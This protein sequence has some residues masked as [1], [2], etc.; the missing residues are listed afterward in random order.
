M[1]NENQPA[2]FSPA[3]RRGFL[4]ALGVHGLGIAAGFPSLLGRASQALACQ[5]KPKEEMPILVVLELA[6][7]NDGLN[8]VVPHGID[9]Y[10]RYR[11]KLAISPDE[12]LKLDEQFG[13][14]P[15]LPGLEALF[16]E[17]QLA[18]VHGC[19]YP[20]PSFSHTESALHWHSAL[21]QEEDQL[22]WLGRV[23]DLRDSRPRT[24]ALVNLG[25]V[26]SRAVKSRRHWPLLVTPSGDFEENEDSRPSEA[27]GVEDEVLL[28]L[29]RLPPLPGN[30]S[31][32][33]IHDM[34]T[35][36]AETAALV[37]S[38][39]RNYRTPIDYGEGEISRQ[40]ALIASLIDVEFPARI[41]FVSY[42]GFDTHVAQHER[43]SRRISF[44]GRAFAAFLADLQRMG[45]SDRVASLVF[46]EFG[47]RPHENSG[48][49]TDH[50]TATP[51]LLAGGRVRGGFHGSFPSLRDLDEEGNVR[52]TTDF[53]SV[54][55]SLLRDWMGLEDVESVL[56]APFPRLDLFG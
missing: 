15:V 7:G 48:N 11:P 22:G 6:G 42:P 37:E 49:G 13:L 33:F 26:T 14:N 1:K 40:L 44:F 25:E 24:D 8:T 52:Y 20:N 18:V 27:R 53:R 3:T 51:V 17:G 5:G 32:D 34:S 45:R 41:Y 12:V 21:H 39:Y 31:L 36:T 19:G 50:G 23:A 55:A 10:Y 30:P 16:K 56:G 43:H 9:E 2:C 46:T 35:Q 28:G 47:R 38:A 4:K 29:S 54:Y